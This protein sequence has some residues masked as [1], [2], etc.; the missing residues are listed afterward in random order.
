[1]DDISC[2]TENSV[3]KSSRRSERVRKPKI[4]VDWSDIVSKY[5]TSQADTKLKRGKELLPRGLN[6]K[7][8]QRFRWTKDENVKQRRAKDRKRYME[9]KKWWEENRK[10]DKYCSCW[11][12]KCKHS[13]LPKKFEENPGLMLKMIC[14]N[15]ERL[16]IWRKAEEAKEVKRFKAGE[17]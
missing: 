11:K 5:V 4:P 1:M 6:G 9:H 16:E 8:D 17:N 10:R 3:T 2:E 15:R 12:K 13:K 7:I 14:Q